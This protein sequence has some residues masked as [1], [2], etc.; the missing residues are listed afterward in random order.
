MFKA[1]F[2]QLSRPSGAHTTLM[3]KD[4]SYELLALL[5]LL[6]NSGELTRLQL[7]N[8]GNGSVT[9]AFVTDFHAVFVAHAER[10]DSL[11]E[12]AIKSMRGSNSS[13]KLSRHAH[14]C[15]LCIE[16]FRKANAQSLRQGDERSVDNSYDDR[17]SAVITGTV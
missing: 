16:Q 2:S 3:L 12:Y 9:V 10:Y 14:P 1:A 13:Y 8:G 15:V 4:Y 5:V 7:T 17:M 6:D 11:Y